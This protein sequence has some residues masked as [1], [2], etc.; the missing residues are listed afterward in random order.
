MDMFVLVHQEI[1]SGEYINLQEKSVFNCKEQY[2]YI[3]Y[4]KPDYNFRDTEPYINQS[5]NLDW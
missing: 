2:I 5:L 4:P 1:C 3:Y